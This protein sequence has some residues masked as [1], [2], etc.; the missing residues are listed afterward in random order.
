VKVH[1]TV[2]EKLT[3]VLRGVIGPGRVIRGGR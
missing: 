1:G 2:A 3:V